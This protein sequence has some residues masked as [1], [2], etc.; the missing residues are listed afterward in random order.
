MLFIPNKRMSL[1]LPKFFFSTKYSI[2]TIF[3]CGIVVS[4]LPI[5]L[6]FNDASFLGLILILGF[7]VSVLVSPE[8]NLVSVYK[9]I[10]PLAVALI[11]IFS[12]I[13]RCSFAN[14]DSVYEYLISSLA[15]FIF[16]FSFY[17][18]RNWI[19]GKL[20]PPNK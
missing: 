16:F 9:Q 4:V 12:F 8:K 3:V 11:F 13:G 7:S 1:I 2:L 6:G 19:W 20:K 17:C 14:R 18:C 5:F 15:T 10:S